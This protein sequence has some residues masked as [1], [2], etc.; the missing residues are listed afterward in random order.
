VNWMTWR[1]RLTYLLMSLFLAWHLVAVVVA[2]LQDSNAVVDPLRLV[3]HPYLSFF[4]LDTTWD[5]FS[6]IGKGHQFRYVVEDGAGKE[7]TFVPIK[8]F[9]WYLPS[10]RWF[11]RV[12]QSIMTYPELYAEFFGKFYCQKHSSMRPVAVTLFEIQENDFQ[13]ADHLRG[14]HPLEP[15]FIN[16]NPLIRVFCD[17]GLESSDQ[18]R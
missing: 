7:H 6:P 12:Y 16:A 11:E 5:F 9:Y 18:K 4:G 10:H 14:K 2:P 15:A 1:G 8:D 13:P 17:D 3:Y